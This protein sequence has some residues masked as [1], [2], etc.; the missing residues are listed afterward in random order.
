MPEDVVTFVGAL[1][2][3]KAAGVV[4]TEIS[5]HQRVACEVAVRFYRQFC[6]DAPR[7]TAF[8]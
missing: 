5:V 7:S 3:V 6:G 4:G 2:G 1:A 8:P